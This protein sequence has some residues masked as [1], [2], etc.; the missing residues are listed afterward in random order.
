[1][2]LI[3]Y[4]RNFKYNFNYVVFLQPT[5][6]MRKSGELDE[7]IKHCINKKFDTVFSSIDYKPFVEKIKNKLKPITFEPKKRK[8]RQEITDINEKNR[9][10]LH[11]S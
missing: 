8:R 5:T 2:L 9:I 7:A 10:L 1:M 3:L 4:K 6:P 11:N